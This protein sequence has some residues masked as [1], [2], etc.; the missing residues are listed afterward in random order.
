[1]IPV[2]LVASGLHPGGRHGKKEKKISIEHIAIWEDTAEI[3]LRFLLV[4]MVRRLTHSPWSGDSSFFYMIFYQGRSDQGGES[5]FERNWGTTVRVGK[6]ELQKREKCLFL[7]LRSLKK[8]FRLF[9]LSKFCVSFRGKI[10][11]L[12]PLIAIRF[13]TLLIICLGI[14]SPALCTLTRSALKRERS[15]RLPIELISEDFCSFR[16][17]MIFFIR[18]RW[19]V[20]LFSDVLAS[21]CY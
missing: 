14:C 21:K 5:P 20:P 2:P 17:R 4:I 18:F 19:F 11:L 7:L 10:R 1:M 13:A 8:N 16:M 3:S 12:S 9:P 15:S 6:L